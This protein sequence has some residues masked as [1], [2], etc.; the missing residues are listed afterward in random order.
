MKR[1]PT[2]IAVLTI[3]ATVAIAQQPRRMGPHGGPGGPPPRELA[4]YLGLTA[5]QQTQIDALQ[6][7][8]RTTADPL[9]EQRRAEDEKL[10]SMLESANPDPTAIG[11]QA[12]ALYAIDEQLRSARETTDAKIEA[13]LNADQKVK[14]EAFIAAQRM[15]GPPPPPPR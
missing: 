15:H 14:F 10:R 4:K 12:L 1:I 6:Q 7:S 8:L 13:L 5:E 3:I 11:K 9:F 2:L